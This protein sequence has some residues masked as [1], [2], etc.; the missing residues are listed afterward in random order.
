M[1]FPHA[2]ELLNDPIVWISDVGASMH[3]K[4]YCQG[5]ENMK[6]NSK[7]DGITMGNKV[8]ENIKAR[9]YW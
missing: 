5:L 7:L 3:M 6:K 9:M 1:G 8:V 2:H 4:P